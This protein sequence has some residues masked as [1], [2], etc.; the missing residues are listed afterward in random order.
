MDVARSI[1][2]LRARVD[3]WRASGARIGFVPTMGALHRGHLSLVER[4]AGL[5]DKVVVSVFVN[6][7]QFAPNEDLAAYPRQEARD[8]ALLAEKTRCDLV[9]SPDVAEIYPAGFQTKIEVALLSKGLCG[10]SRPHFFAGVATVVLK[11]L[12]QVRPDLAVFGEKDFQQLLVIRRLVR[13]L[14]LP[15]EIV[16]APIIREEDGL[17]M[18]S[19]NAYLSPEERRIAGRLNKVIAEIAGKLEKGVA[20]DV[21]LAA[22]RAALEAAGFS[23]IDYLDARSAEDL[24]PLGPGPIGAGVEARVFVAVFL[25]RTRL[26]DNWPVKPRA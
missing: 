19:R 25:G 20:V 17:A 10:D 9:Y 24:A 18:S 6:P 7:K 3:I 22:G 14:D 4:A 23:A 15:V 1:E 21:A 2:A 26:I 12:N 5:A 8:I 13:D 11:L 16:G